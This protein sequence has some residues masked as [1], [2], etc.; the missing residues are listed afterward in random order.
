MTDR[1]EH[2]PLLIRRI[3]LGDRA[4]PRRHGRHATSSSSSSR[5]TRRSRPAARR[6]RPDDVERVAHFLGTRPADLRPV[7][8]VPQE[9]ASCHQR[10][11]GPLVRQPRRASTRSS[12]EAAPVTA[13]LVFGGAIL[14]MLI[15]IPIG[16]LSALRPRS[17]LD[18]ASMV[19]VLIGI[20]AHPVWIGLIFAY[21]FGYKLGHD[22]DHRATATS[23]T[24]RRGNCGGPVQWAYHLILPWMTFAILFAAL[25]VRLI[26]ANVMETMN[27]D[28]V[29]TARA[30]GAPE[31]PV[32]ALAHPAERDAAGRD[33]ARHGHRPR[34]RRRGLHRDDLQPAR[35]SGRTAIQSARQLRPTRRCMGI[36]VFAT[37]AI[38]VFNLIVDLLYAASTRGSG[39]PRWRCSKSTTS[40]RTSGPTTASSRPS[41]ASA[42][43]VEKGKTLGI[44]GESGSR[45]E[46]HLPD[47]HGPEQPT[48]NT[49]TTG[50][51]LFKGEDLLTMSAA[52]AARDPR[53]RHRDD[54]PGPDDVAEPGAHDRQAARSRRSCS[55]RTSRSKAG[56]R[57]RAS[58]C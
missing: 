32:H 55:T 23:S 56:A 7:R 24:H 19:F 36:V 41:T 17:L 30:K 20:S 52:R 37:T 31:S 8:Q 46:R 42:S 33:D 35:A 50:E 11:L 47:D 3:A 49:I 51:A 38:I 43:R 6:A 54:L 5:P 27:E 13:S 21:F 48:R 10:S 16:I 53:Q 14:W 29:R 44:V 15:A 26:R 39:S 57:T 18:R 40:R 4:L 28:Y 2:G 1:H 22:A 45:Q 9:P 12:R 25:Y 58:S 34:A